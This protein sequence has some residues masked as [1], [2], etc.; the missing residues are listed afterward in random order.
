MMRKLG[1]GI[2]IAVSC[3]MQIMPR[4]A[5]VTTFRISGCLVLALLRQVF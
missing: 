3:Q 4:F 2:S 5:M 1:H